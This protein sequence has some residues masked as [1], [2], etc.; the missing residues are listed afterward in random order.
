VPVLTPRLSSLW[1]TLVAPRHA[2]VGRKLIDG[3]RNETTV[4]DDAAARAFRVRPVG[5]QE[6]IR[7]AVDGLPPEPPRRRGAAAILALLVFLAAPLAAVRSVHP[8][9]LA[10]G[11][12]L[13]L[14]AWSVW[15]R[16]G[17]REGRLAFAAFTLLL[18]GV[19]VPCA[20]WAVVPPAVAAALLFGARSPAAGL[21]ALSALAWPFL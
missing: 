19:A 2:R 18:I 4:A 5:V 1:L 17:L 14:A 11:T 6:A 16:D 7:R 13:G 20:A 12:L 15:R 10:V 8:G 21:A 3:V 9:K